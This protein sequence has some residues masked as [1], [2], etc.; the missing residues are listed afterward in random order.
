MALDKP[1]HVKQD[2][3]CKRL[4]P[5][6]QK[7][8]L[9]RRKSRLSA[10]FSGARKRALLAYGEQATLRLKVFRTLPSQIPAAAVFS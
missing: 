2:A 5:V 1:A 6:L 3:R 10:G 4:H 9:G 7:P 8:R